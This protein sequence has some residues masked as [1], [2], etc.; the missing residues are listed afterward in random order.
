MKL[1]KEEDIISLEKGDFLYYVDH[2]KNVF[3]YRFCNK[4]KDEYDGSYHRDIYFANGTIIIS[5]YKVV[6]QC[7][8]NIKDKNGEG[9]EK[10]SYYA[11][12]N[13]LEESE[14]IGEV[15]QFLDGD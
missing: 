6:L 4:T 11:L 12:E 7:I 10:N 8:A 3:L 5:G 14:L 2:Y 15:L 1:L 13:E 9:L